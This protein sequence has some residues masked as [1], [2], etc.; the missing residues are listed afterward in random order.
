MEIRIKSP[1]F[2]FYL[3]IS[4][5]TQHFCLINLL[6]FIKL[7]KSIVKNC[8]YMSFILYTRAMAFLP[9]NSY[10]VPFFATTKCS[11]TL[12]NVP[13]KLQANNN[14]LHTSRVFLLILYLRSILFIFIPFILWQRTSFAY[15]HKFNRFFFGF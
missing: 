14:H 8:V 13:Y 15:T 9:S 1:F 2:V 5:F 11:S 7:W 3:Q 12:I 10:L 4:L 6:F